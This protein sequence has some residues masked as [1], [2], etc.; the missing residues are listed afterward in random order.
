[1]TDEFTVYGLRGA[2]RTYGGEIGELEVADAGVGWMFEEEGLA[3]AAVL[4]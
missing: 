2:E 4:R 1:M 3:V